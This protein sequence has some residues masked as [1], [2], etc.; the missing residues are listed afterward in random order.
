[1]CYENCWRS[2]ISILLDFS[3][4][5]NIL[6]FNLNYVYVTLLI[7]SLNK[8]KLPNYQA[9]TDEL[10]HIC[11]ICVVFRGI[12]RTLTTFKIELFATLVKMKMIHD[13]NSHHDWLIFL[14]LRIIS[15]C[16][17]LKLF[18]MLNTVFYLDH[19]LKHDSWL[20][21]FSVFHPFNFI[22]FIFGTKMET[23]LCKKIAINISKIDL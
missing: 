14:S 5:I 10:L 8:F 2:D 18:L 16:W 12:P 9:C 7:Y 21:L 17:F 22:T 13:V 19:E 6:I 1:M 23:S 3:I 20:L 4:F 11:N 15:L